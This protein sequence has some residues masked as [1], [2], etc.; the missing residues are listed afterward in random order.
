MENPSGHVEH[1]I[2][3][4]ISPRVIER[5]PRHACHKKA[6]AP[7]RRREVESRASFLRSCCYVE[8]LTRIGQRCLRYRAW[9]RCASVCAAQVCLNVAG[10]TD[11]TADIVGS[12]TLQWLSLEISPDIPV[13]ERWVQIAGGDKFTLKTSSSCNEPELFWMRCSNDSVR[14]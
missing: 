11:F 12:K 14:G 2:A 5:V 1:F 13:V 6:H 4:V 3:N 9:H 7:R 8:R 10:I